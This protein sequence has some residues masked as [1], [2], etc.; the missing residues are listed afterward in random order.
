[1][2][3]RLLYFGPSG[4]GDWCFIYPS[5]PAL[6]ESVSCKR[7]VLVLP[8]DNPG[9]RLLEGNPL[10]ERVI[11][12]NRKTRGLS[13]VIYAL[14]SGRLLRWIRTERFSALAVSYLSNQA[15]FL[16]LAALSGIPLRIGLASSMGATLLQHL[17]FTRL[18]KRPDTAG[19]VAMHRAFAES[20]SSTPIAPLLMPPPLT[21][22]FPHA[23]YV[24]LGIGGGRDAEWRFW[25][26]AH[27]KRLIEL[28][29]DLHFVLMGG[30]HNDRKQ[31]DAIAANKLSNVTDLVDRLDMKQAVAILAEARLVIGNDSG[32]TNIA[33]TL[34]RPTLCVY[35]P[36]AS[37]LTGPALL[38]A[39]P[40]SVPV[41]CGPCFGD[42]QDARTAR[43]CLRRICL[44]RVT[45]EQVCA[46]VR[47]HLQQAS[48]A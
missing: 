26:A 34:G 15:D 35:G 16:L 1:M 13:L 48:R 28:N 22:P 8:Y 29:P 45:P 25:P 6:L 12:L 23:S 14:R 7:A 44:E 38:G 37:N 21:T 39:E 2:N 19:K 3:D 40:L 17:A 46:A 32:V 47:R 9:N 24:V 31:A 36:T 42:N 27:W 43:G 20:A 10:I 30:G 5:L 18:V 33:A 11:Y 41:P 4:I